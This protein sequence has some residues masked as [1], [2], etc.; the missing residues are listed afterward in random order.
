MYGHSY[1]SDQF[2]SACIISAQVT[3]FIVNRGTYAD[4]VAPTVRTKPRDLTLLQ[5]WGHAHPFWET[6]AQ[7][8]YKY[9]HAPETTLQFNKT[10]IKLIV[11]YK[12]SRI[13]Q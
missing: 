13:P 11:L 2:R 9:G 10:N 1:F 5:V 12:N 8:I 7:D 4:K 6:R 3:L